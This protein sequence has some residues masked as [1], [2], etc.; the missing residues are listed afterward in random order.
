MP[1]IEQNFMPNNSQSDSVSLQNAW[2]IFCTLF[3]VVRKYQAGRSDFPRGL[4]GKNKASALRA[5]GLRPESDRW[6]GLKDEHFPCG[7]QWHHQQARTKRTG[8]TLVEGCARGAEM[9]GESGYG[10]QQYEDG[11]KKSCES[12]GTFGGTPSG[13]RCSWFLEARDM[14]VRSSVFLPKPAEKK[15]RSD[16]REFKK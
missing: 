16:E 3:G 14:S 8:A 10:I 15:K 12:F 6:R 4:S 13:V 9:P 5:A 7:N 1:N 11:C 2:R